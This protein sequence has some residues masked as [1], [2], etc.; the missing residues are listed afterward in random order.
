MKKIIALFI[1]LILVASPF[2]ASSVEQPKVEIHFAWF[3]WGIV[4]VVGNSEDEAIHHV[5]LDSISI[6]GFVF[7]GCNSVDYLEEIGSYGVGYLIVPIFGFGRCLVT[8]EI[9]Y[10]YE[11]ITYN[12]TL[13][14]LFFV[15]GTT[16]LLLQEW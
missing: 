14:G 7:I 3:H 9:S 1:L 16:T 11:G 10:E 4:I 6:A 15:F 12:E 13:H 8:A 5:C 2:F